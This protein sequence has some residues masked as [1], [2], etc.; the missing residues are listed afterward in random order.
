MV[1]ALRLLNR[2]LKCIQI[3]GL[4]FTAT[5]TAI[6][7][8]ND[9]WLISSLQDKTCKSVIILKTTFVY[10]DPRDYY[11]FRRCLNRLFKSVGQRFWRITA[12]I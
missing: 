4:I 2:E 5:K 6:D 10:N 9:H 12:I 11:A 8:D 7:K 1:W 3:F